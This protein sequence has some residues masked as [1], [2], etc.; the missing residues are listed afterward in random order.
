MSNREAVEACLEQARHDIREYP[1]VLVPAIAVRDELEEYLA[2][3]DNAIPANVV[4]RSR[5]QLRMRA[6]IDAS[7]SDHEDNDDDDDNDDNDDEDGSDAEQDYGSTALDRAEFE[8]FQR[9]VTRDA[10]EGGFPAAVYLAG[11]LEQVNPDNIPPAVMRAI[12]E[13]DSDNDND[14]GGDN[15]SDDEVNDS[16]D[17]SMPPLE[18]ANRENGSTVS[19]PCSP[20]RQSI[21]PSAWRR[22]TRPAW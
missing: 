5:S 6:H 17:D 2:D 3:E 15:Q 12:R 18:S 13:C 14:G 11:L 21:V 20:S 19:P 7:F 10:A 4:E 1:G 9:Q 16:D 22:L 8:S